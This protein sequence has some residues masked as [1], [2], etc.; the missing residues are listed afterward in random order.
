MSFYWPSALVCSQSRGGRLC[1]RPL[2]RVPIPIGAEVLLSPLPHLTSWEETLTHALD[3]F[4]ASHPG[5][6]GKPEFPVWLC[7]QKV[8]Q[9]QGG[10][11]ASCNGSF[12]ASRAR[13]LIFHLS[14]WQMGGRQLRDWRLAMGVKA[15]RGGNPEIEISPPKCIR[16]LCILSAGW[17]YTRPCA[18]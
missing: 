17:M 10:Q 12:Q 1:P 8:N 4:G 2:P 14:S 6:A 11:G 9:Q 5:P 7:W 15:P 18:I 13:R 16:V 3:S